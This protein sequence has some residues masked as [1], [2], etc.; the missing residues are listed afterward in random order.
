MPMGNDYGLSLL[1]CDSTTVAITEEDRRRASLIVA[2]LAADADDC[3]Q[4]LTI[5]GLLEHDG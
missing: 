4:L 2:G 5:I 3:R 1:S